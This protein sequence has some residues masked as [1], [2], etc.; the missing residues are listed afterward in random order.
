METEEGAAEGDFYDVFDIPTV[1]LFRDD[2]QLLGRWEGKPPAT[3][4]LQGLICP[5][6][7]SAAA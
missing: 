5:G 6:G 7:Q 2:S 4:E 3:Q 1:L